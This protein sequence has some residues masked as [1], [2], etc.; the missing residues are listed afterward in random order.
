MSKTKKLLKST[1]K[2]IQTDSPPV[3]SVA[4]TAK[5][6]KLRNIYQILGDN[7]LQK[8][9]TLD[10]AVYQGKI[11]K[12]SDSDLKEEAEKY[13]YKHIHSREITIKNLMES[14][15]TYTNTFS[16]SY[17]QVAGAVPNAEIKNEKLKS[18]LRAAR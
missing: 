8:Y 15:Y 6:K 2:V 18:I 7:G 11:E 17:G 13:G 3:D 14:F 1:G 12:F 16:D 9:G 5:D 4:P 10:P